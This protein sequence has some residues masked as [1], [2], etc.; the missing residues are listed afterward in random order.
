[1]PE[2]LT[3]ALL[4]IPLIGAYALFALGISVI[5]RA[6]RVLNLAHG[7]MAMLPAYLAYSMVN[8]GVPIG[9]AL[10]LAVASGAA[11]GVV[12]ERVFV[13]RLRPQGPTAQTVGTVAVTGLLIAVVAKAWGTTPLLAP[14]VFPRGVV[15][16]GESGIRSGEIG[17]FLTGVVVSIALFQFFKRTQFGLAMRGAAQNRRAASLMGIDPDRAAAVAWAL[18]GGLAALAG[19]MLAA[20]TNLDPYT[21]S[22]Q[23]LPAFVAALIGGLESLTGALRG[24]AA[25]GLAF[26]IVP[27]FAG[28]PGIGRIA[29]M[30]GARELVL[31]IVT[32]VVLALRGRRISGAPQTEAGLATSV[33]PFRPM[34][35]RRLLPT[36]L[37][38]GLFILVWPLVAP[39]SVLGTSLLAVQLSLVAVALVVLT[40]W[41]GQISLAHASFVGIAALVTGMVARGFG[42]AFPVSMIGAAVAAAGAAAVLGVVALRV[43]GLYLAVATLIFAW[44]CDTFLFRSPWLGA[45]TSGSTLPRQV[46]GIPGGWPVIDFG[47]RETLFWMSAPVLALAVLA[48]ATLRDSKTGRA[49]FAVR[50]SEMAAASL[51]INV[52]RTKLVAFAISGALAGFSGHLLMLDQR[53]V[54]PNQFIFT[55]S[56]QFLAIA[57]VGGLGSLGGALAAAAVFAG[58]NELFYNASGALAGWL[59]IITSGLLTFVLIAYPGGLAAAAPRLGSLGRLVGAPV[60]RRI[61]ARRAARAVRVAERASARAEE[62]PARRSQ[63][64]R[65]PATAAEDWLTEAFPVEVS[66][67]QN[68]EVHV[69]AVRIPAAADANPNGSATEDAG[70]LPDLVRLAEMRPAEAYDAST[71][72]ERPPVLEADGIVVKFGGLTAVHDASLSVRRGE[73]T[74][75]IGPNGAG[76]TTLFN[77]MLGLNEPAGGVVRI[78]GSDATASPPHERA[79]LGVA[80]TFQVLQLFGELTVF[81][82]LLVATHLHNPSGVWSNLTGSRLTL[83]AES[84][85]RER[86]HRVLG[87]LGLDDIADRSVRGLPFG[88]LRMVELGRALVTG[89]KLVLLDEPA[90]GLNDSETDRLASVIVGMRALGVTVLLIEHDVRMVTGVCDFIYVLDQGQIIAQGTPAEI[91]RNPAVIAAYLG[92]DPVAEPEPAEV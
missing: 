8:V 14:Q 62:R 43:R 15:T 79:A 67:P 54:V 81:D 18:G 25:T 80:R 60:A 72:H 70:S 49:F 44:M 91:Q 64:R 78:H 23:V 36:L 73:I 89:A 13:R 9:I 42:L 33:R 68:G 47:S 16:I 77:A 37:I 41:V 51:G 31:T 12:V 1:M 83:A 19:V 5:Y 27:Y 29:R 75:L 2:I 74:G 34:S 84:E 48:V 39:Y 53:T 38:A 86:A 76:K 6:S 55:V 46:L 7:A 45:G 22:L 28:T 20:V 56:L 32:L 11:L 50:G 71:R 21:L 4:S 30:P 69:D 90:S 85:V 40:G 3:Y 66:A 17:L 82:N 92:G 58:L 24:A 35:A 63:A 57:V 52:V 65:S 59:D 87:L 88:V 61:A 10:I 26:G